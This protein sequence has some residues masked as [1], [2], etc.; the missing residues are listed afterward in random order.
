MFVSWKR[1]RII[2]QMKIAAQLPN[3]AAMI[4]R[5]SDEIWLF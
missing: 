4:Y 3:K 1:T 2:S 5:V